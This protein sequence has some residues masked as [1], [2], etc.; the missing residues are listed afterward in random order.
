MK[1]AFVYAVFLALL[2]NL[3]VFAANEWREGDGTETILGT[4]NASDIDTILFQNVVDPIDRVMA[5]FRTGA[6]LEYT[7][8][9][10]ITVESGAVVCENSDGSVRRMRANASD[11]TLTWANID[12][13][14][15]ETATTYYVYAVADAD[16]ANFT[17]V[18]SKNATSP[19]GGET[20]Y[21]RLGSFYN[22]ASGDIE[23]VKSDN[24]RFTMSTGTV[25]H[26]GTISVPSGYSADQ[27]DW[28]VSMNTIQ[29]GDRD[30]S[31]CITHYCAA[32]SARVVSAYGY[33]PD[34]NGCGGYQYGT[35]N[36]WIACYK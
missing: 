31:Y 21:L 18:I 24:S 14:S 26:G 28:G 8:G 10:T 20:Y 4:E 3:P 34:S 33:N 16:S 32:S 35:A 19:Q 13:G 29:H 7:T 15:E 30:T 17:G 6:L 1:K 5:D 9:A 2:L 11:L 12:T 36:Y 25:A 22:N 23:Q 27:C